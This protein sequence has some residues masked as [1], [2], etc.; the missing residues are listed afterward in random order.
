MA[1]A[2]LFGLVGSAVTYAVARRWSGSVVALVAPV[3]LLV[4]SIVLG[5]LTPAAVLLQ[6][7][8]FALAAIG[9]AAVRS[10]RNRP[11]LQN[12]AGRTTRAVTTA[13]LLAAATV[14]GFVIGPHL[15]GAD[16]TQRTVF[17]TALTPPIDVTQFASPLAGFRQYTEPNPAKLW[18]RTLLRVE[19]LPAGVPVRF[20]ALD[21]YDNLVWGAGNAASRGE[22]DDAAAGSSF[23]KVGSHIASEGA[24]Q[25]VTATVTVPGRRLPRRVAADL[26]H[27]HGPRLRRT[28]RRHAR[29]R[30]AL[31]RRHRH[32]RAADPARRRRLLHRHRP[33]RR[34]REDAAQGARRRRRPGRRRP[35]RPRLPRREGRRV[36]RPG[37]RPVGE[38]RRDGPRPAGR[39]LHRRRCARAT[40]RTPSSRATASPGSSAS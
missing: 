19:G 24:G 22:G 2:F 36:D 1:L 4:A 32:R 39:R 5:T 33:R 11:A 10:N 18:D 38:V 40:T 27:R 20:A 13:A 6:G 35:R 17:R 21:S 7:A 16:D 31:Q 12:G 30:A 8:V 34:A 15:P 28:P 14:G 37:R 9:W 3:A 26:R 25:E 23:R 29:R